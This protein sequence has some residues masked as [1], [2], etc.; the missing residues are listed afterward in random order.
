[1]VSTFCGAR[2]EGVSWSCGELRGFADIPRV[3]AVFSF[4]RGEVYCCTRNGD[5]G[6]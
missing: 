3:G 6:G 2:R 5:L 4:Q 1:M